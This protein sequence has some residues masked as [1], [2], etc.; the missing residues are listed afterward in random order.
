MRANRLALV[1]AAAGLVLAPGCANLGGVPTLDMTVDKPTA[2][3]GQPLQF[4]VTNHGEGDQ[5][6]PVPVEVLAHNGST[7]RSYEDVTAGRGIPA[8]GQITVAWNGLDDDG[9]PV[10]WG[11][12]TV[13]VLGGELRGTVQILQPD[14]YAITVDP[15]PRETE[16]GDEMTFL[17]NNT[18]SVWLNGTL[19]VAAGKDDTVLYNTTTPPIELAPGETYE[20]HWQGQDPDGEDPEPDKYLV[21]A[22]MTLEG[23]D[24]P[25]PFARDVFTLTEGDR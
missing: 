24:Q 13:E 18:G 17:V 2:E 11:N 5:P 7:V 9:R 1:L 22:R 3:W 15:K 16:A 6:A 10:M 25:T 21:A 20:A 19:T 4:T 14:N 8:G 23:D 12:Y